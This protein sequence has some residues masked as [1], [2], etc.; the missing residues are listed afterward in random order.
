[1]IAIVRPIL[2]AIT[3]IV[4]VFVSPFVAIYPVTKPLV[5]G[6]VV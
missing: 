5:Q 1:M 4:V 2:C 3:A 6:G